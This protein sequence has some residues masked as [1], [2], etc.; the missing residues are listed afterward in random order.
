MSVEENDQIPI[1]YE[2]L[3]ADFVDIK[4]DVNPYLCK[5]QLKL[6]QIE[7]VLVLVDGICDDS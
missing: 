3:L 6:F 4:G 2:P 5:R 1:L 7:T